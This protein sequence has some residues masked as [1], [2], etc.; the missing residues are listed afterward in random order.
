[1]IWPHVIINGTFHQLDSTNILDR[2]AGFGSLL[3]STHKTKQ[4]RRRRYDEAL[5]LF[6]SAAVADGACYV[7]AIRAHGGRG[8]AA[9]GLDVFKQ[10]GCLALASQLDMSKRVHMRHLT[11]RQ[12]GMI[13]GFGE[14]SKERVRVAPPEMFSLRAQLQAAMVCGRLSERQAVQARVEHSRSSPACVQLSCTQHVA[15]LHASP[16]SVSGT[17]EWE[18]SGHRLVTCDGA[19]HQRLHIMLT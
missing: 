3:P 14:E 7:Q 9:R 15:L 11:A 19:A 16:H 18:T 6:S 1:M 4:N 13:T 8:E 17:H 2:L 10:D 5:A 12:H